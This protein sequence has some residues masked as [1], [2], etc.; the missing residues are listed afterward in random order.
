M[1]DMTEKIQIRM[2]PEELAIL[3]Y[4]AEQEDIGMSEWIR[5]A[6]WDRAKELQLSID[7]RLVL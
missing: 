6:I 5:Q 7:G 3:R 4:L 1:A 2:T